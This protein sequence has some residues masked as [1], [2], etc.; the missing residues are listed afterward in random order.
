MEQLVLACAGVMGTLAL[1]GCGTN[2]G[3]G[4]TS[5]SRADVIEVEARQDV[6]VSEE[7]L[8][9][10]V[11][12]TLKAGDAAAALCYVEEAQSNAGVTGSAIK[13]ESRDLT[14]YAAVTDLPEGAANRTMLFDVDQDSLRSGLPTC[15]VG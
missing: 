7:P 8:G 4:S 3:A 6:L 5:A 13:I 10:V 15:S 1:V 2:Q 14:G 9:D 11:V 12:G